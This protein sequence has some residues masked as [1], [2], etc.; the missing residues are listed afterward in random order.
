MK[1]YSSFIFDTCAFDPKTGKIELRYSLDDELHF[2]ETLF[3]PPSQVPS[4]NSSSH[5]TSSPA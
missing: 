1:Q 2:T 3:L 5:S 4:P